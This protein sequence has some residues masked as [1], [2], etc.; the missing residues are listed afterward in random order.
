[1]QIKSKYKIARRLGPS[2]FEK[3]QTQKYAARASRKKEPRGMRGMTDFGKAL[4]EKQRARFTYLIN[5][6]QF[7]RYAE[8]ANAESKKKPE[9]SL[10]EKLETRLDNTVYRMGLAST[11]LAARQMVNHGHIL[12]NG[13]RV[14]IPSAKAEVNDIIAIAARSRGSK[15]FAGLVEKAKEYKQPEWVTFDIAKF[16]GKVLST[17]KL[18][19]TELAFDIA[20]ILDFYKR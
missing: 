14:S 16:E 15:L 17:P 5:E 11:R 7:K 6:R 19:P 8:N 10:F 9:E 20:A 4:L 1:M 2:V 18:T 3:T 12:V 13:R